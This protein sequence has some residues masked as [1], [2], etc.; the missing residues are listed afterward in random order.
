MIVTDWAKYAPYFTEKEFQCK[1]TGRCEMNAEF[2]DILLAIRIEYGKPLRVTSGFR[3]PSHP[4]EARKT[5]GGEHT[6]GRCVDFGIRGAEAVH[7]L[8]IALKHG[9]TRIGVNQRGNA[10]FLHLGL[11][12]SRLPNPAIWSYG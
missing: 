11:G 3:D 8:S 4:T 1:H 2:M 9:I 6:K 12:A 5:S 7:L 10:R